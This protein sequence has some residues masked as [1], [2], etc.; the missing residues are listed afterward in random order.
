MNR[1]LKYF[2]ALLGLLALA[3]VRSFQEELFY[4]PLI[5]FFKGNYSGALAPDFNYWKLTLHTVLRYLLNSSISI[6]IIVLLFSKSVL[7]FSVTI[8]GILLLVLLPIFLLL[9]YSMSTDLYFILFYVRR[10]LIQPLL[11]LLLIPAFYYQQNIK[12]AD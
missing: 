9:L 11:I 4:D 2:L 3:S 6:A 10:F 7:K 8:Y 5:K 1:Y 12:K